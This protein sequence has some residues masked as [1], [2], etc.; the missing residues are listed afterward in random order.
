MTPRSSRRQLGLVLVVFVATLVLLGGAWALLARSRDAGPAPSG[1]AGVAASPILGVPGSGS[2][3]SPDHSGSSGP[4]AS[5]EVTVVITGAGDIAD[6]SLDGARLTSDLLLG[7]PGP[8]FT[9]GDN[10]YENGS[11]KD[12]AACYAPTWGRVLDRTLLPVAGNHDWQTAGAAG[13]KAYFGTAAEGPDGA[14]WYARDV[15]AWHVIVLDS[16]CAVVGGCDDASP[17]GRWLA[18]DLAANDAR[19]TL[20]LYHHPRF[21]SGEHGSEQQVQPLW[22]Q[23]HAAGVD[24][25]VNGHDHDYERFAPMD[26][27]GNVQRP[28]GMREIVAG[29]GGAGLR[30]FKAIATN[31]E[32]RLAGSWGVLRLNLHVANYD[33]EFLPVGGATAVAD[34]GSTPCH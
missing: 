17:Q 32:F 30:S 11:T 16:D 19:C 12:F 23:L 31:S 25:V 14:T 10:A 33:W 20:A 13:Y 22:A 21:S 1:S 34:A 9:V 15:G 27:A 28:G 3:G 6:C 2:P 24:L 4:P 26:A 8:F 5:G 7:E 18:A 29:T